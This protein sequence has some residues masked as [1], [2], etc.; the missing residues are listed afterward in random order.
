MG[1]DA[2]LFSRKSLGGRAH[3]SFQALVVFGLLPGPWIL[4][5]ALRN[6]S[7][8]AA[9]HIPLHLKQAKNTDGEGHIHVPSGKAP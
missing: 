8:L 5:H 3:S 6:Q 9:V 1:A 7:S 4:S 2:A